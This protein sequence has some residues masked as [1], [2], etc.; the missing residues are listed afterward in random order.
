MNTPLSKD[1]IEKQIKE[2]INR[3]L[4]I[5]QNYLGDSGP[6]YITNSEGQNHIFVAVNF[7]GKLLKKK[8]QKIHNDLLAKIQN[9]VK[10]YEIK[11]F[12]EDELENA[13]EYHAGMPS[14]R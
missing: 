14:L 7:K 5:E 8:K 1:Q 11:I 6:P 12:V 4:R 10:D 3:Y 13:D 2:V 9:L